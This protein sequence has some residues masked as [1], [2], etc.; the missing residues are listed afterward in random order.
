ML[1]IIAMGIIFTLARGLK[2]N[3]WTWLIGTAL[4]GLFASWLCWLVTGFF[5]GGGLV[6]IPIAGLMMLIHWTSTGRTVAQ[7]YR[8]QL[9]ETKQ[10]AEAVIEQQYPKDLVVLSSY[11]D[12]SQQ[13][14]FTAL[15]NALEDSGIK[16]YVRAGGI[17]NLMVREGDLEQAEEIA[18]GGSAEPAR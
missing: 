13:A 8:V 17:T 14:Q 4:L 15:R 1:T 12:Q 10:Q 6:F 9:A 3:P 11:L 2:M 18:A 16:T 5:V 7:E